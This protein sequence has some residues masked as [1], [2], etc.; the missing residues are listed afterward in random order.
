MITF[1]G[2]AY[3]YKQFTFCIAIYY[4]S[5]ANRSGYNYES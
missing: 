1:V 5:F 3:C 4:I 2:R